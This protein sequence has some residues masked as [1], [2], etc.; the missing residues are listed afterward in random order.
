M[1][2]YHSLNVALGLI[3]TGFT[4]GLA[5]AGGQL[6][7]FA[8]GGMN[9]KGMV[10]FATA[11]YGS[12]RAVNAIAEG[13]KEIAAHLKAGDTEAKRM[14]ETFVALNAAAESTGDNLQKYGFIVGGIKSGFESAKAFFTG[15]T[16]HLPRDEAADAAATKAAEARAE[17]QA[18]FKARNDR[19]FA[20]ES[21]F[22]KLRNELSSED[23]MKKLGP[24]ERRVVEARRAFGGLAGPEDAEARK[25]AREAD[26]AERQKELSKRNTERRV[27]DALGVVAEEQANANKPQSQTRGGSTAALLL[28]SREEYMARVKAQQQADPEKKD[29]RRHKR[30]VERA[31]KET[32]KWLK[33]LLEA[34]GDALSIPGGV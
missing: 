15:D 7:Q 23:E 14:Y 9:V 32:N 21:M 31:Q 2:T 4:Q 5:T 16:S 27:A 3:T 10:Q 25:M 28:G 26:T 34:Q 33:K 29:D 13:S 1:A 17:E 12:T 22:R 30:E 24:R 18:K 11:A 6:K 19:K 8:T 20:E